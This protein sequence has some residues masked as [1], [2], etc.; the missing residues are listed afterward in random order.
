MLNHKTLMLTASGM[1]TAIV[2]CKRAIS[3]VNCGKA[4]IRESYSDTII[5]SSPAFATIDFNLVKSRNEL[6][7][8]AIPSVIQCTKSD[9]EPKKYTNVLKFNRKNVYI[10][11]GGCCQYCGKKVSLSEFTFDHVVPRRSGGTTWWTNIVVCCSR[12]NSQKSSKS[13]DKYHRKLIKQPE[14]LRI[15][16][17]APEHIVNQLAAEIPH[18]TWVDFIYWRVELNDK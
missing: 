16:K 9:Y 12:C 18:E 17:A 1:P 10:R 7:S 14:P 15:N 5:H 11:D 6:I 13:L 8:I 4:I 2:N 3:L